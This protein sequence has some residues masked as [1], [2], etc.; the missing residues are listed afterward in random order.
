MKITVLC[1][2]LD[3]AIWM[4]SLIWQ[5]D[6]FWPAPHAVKFEFHPDG[7][8][9][10]PVRN[11]NLYQQHFFTS[12]SE[13]GIQILKFGIRI[14]PLRNGYL[15]PALF[16]TWP[17]EDEFRNSSRASAWI[18]KFIRS[19]GMNFEIHPEWASFRMNF[20]IHPEWASA[21]ISKFIRND[22]LEI[23]FEY[24]HFFWPARQSMN[25]EIHPEW[26]LKNGGF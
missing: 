15:V 10:P 12:P 14:P 9:I 25:F 24:Q 20:E 13:H 7:I 1:R 16:L 23:D 2:L 6:F 22:R 19:L 8:W 4:P 17:S 21:W 18:S 11:D 5:Q 26:L 3:C